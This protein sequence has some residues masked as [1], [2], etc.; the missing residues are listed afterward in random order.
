MAG[1]ESDQRGEWKEVNQKDDQGLANFH[2]E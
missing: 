2:S 1:K